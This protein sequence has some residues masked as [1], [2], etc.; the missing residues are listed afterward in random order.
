MIE[1][2]MPQPPLDPSARP[3]VYDH[4][5]C[6]EEFF[7]DPLVSKLDT[8]LQFCCAECRYEWEL[9]QHGAF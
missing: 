6:V 1:Q 8:G 3:Y 9:D 7:G 2:P 4:P 5:N